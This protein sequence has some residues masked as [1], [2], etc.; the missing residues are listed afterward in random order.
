[1][2]FVKPPGIYKRLY[3]DLIWEINTNHPDVFLT[4]DDGPDP[5]TTPQILDILQRFN[6]KATFFCTGNRAKKYPEIILKIIDSGHMLG[7]H[8]FD[9]K[10]GWN[11]STEEYFEDVVKCKNVIN[12]SLFRPPYGR[13][14]N[15]QIKKLKNAGF[16]I[17]MWSVLSGDFDKNIKPDKCTSNIINNT[18]PGSI[19]VLHD[20]PG[21]IKVSL[22]VL[23]KSL[24][25]LSKKKYNYAAITDKLIQD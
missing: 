18:N 11:T 9:H 2:Y 15:P 6:A 3:S 22:T 10:N 12:S 19:I 24:E 25:S 16:K 21:F 14:L 4:F 5:G 20:N 17:V 8:G 7:N 1:M 23:E 13:I